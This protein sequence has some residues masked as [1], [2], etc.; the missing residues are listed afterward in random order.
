MR[1]NVEQHTPLGKEVFSTRCMIMGT[2]TRGDDRWVLQAD[3][4]AR[5]ATLKVLSTKHTHTNKCNSNLHPYLQ[6]LCTAS[7]NYYLCVSLQSMDVNQPEFSP[8]FTDIPHAKAQIVNPAGDGDGDGDGAAAE[9]RRP[10]KV[11]VGKVI[12]SSYSRTPGLHP[13]PSDNTHRLL[14]CRMPAHPHRTRHP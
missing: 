7:P 11:A 5:N 8:H 9:K 6:F 12:M 13:R 14:P 2:L 10:G 4:R 3:A 1:F